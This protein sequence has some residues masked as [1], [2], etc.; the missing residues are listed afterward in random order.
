MMHTNKLTLLIAL[1]TFSLASMAQNEKTDK[2]KKYYDLPIIAYDSIPTKLDSEFIAE[3]SQHRSYSTWDKDKRTSTWRLTDT[4]VRRDILRSLRHVYRETHFYDKE[5][6]LRE[7]GYEFRMNNIGEPFRI[8]IW[9]KFD[10]K[11]KVIKTIN[12]DLTHPYNWKKALQRAI[13]KDNIDSIED[14]QLDLITQL[15][16]Q[17]WIVS[18]SNKYDGRSIK[19]KINTR[20]GKESI[21]NLPASVISSIDVM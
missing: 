6:K 10:L 5:G 14:V 1:L 8:G 13:E 7:V 20:T 4:G 12:F 9:K 21:K 19:Y 2:L 18:I 3:V 11:G 15:G 16:T 17:W